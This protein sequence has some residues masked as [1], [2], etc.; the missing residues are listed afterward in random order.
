MV[1]GMTNNE[2]ADDYG[3]PCPLRGGERIEVYEHDADV[4]HVGIIREIRKETDRQFPTVCFTDGMGGADK[5]LAY[6]NYSYNSTG[7]V[8]RYVFAE[9]FDQDVLG[10]KATV[11]LARDK[12]GVVEVLAELGDSIDDVQAEWVEVLVMN[13]TWKPD[14]DAPNYA[15]PGARA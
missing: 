12:P 13:T 14:E 1:D 11:R 10:N 4:V 8:P 2:Y 6:D 3:P 5:F 15:G 7:K 9:G